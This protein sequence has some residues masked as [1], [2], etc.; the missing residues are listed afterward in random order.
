MFNASATALPHMCKHTMH[1]PHVA[2]SHGGDI[3]VRGLVRTVIAHLRLLL[4][5]YWC[6]SDSRWLKLAASAAGIQA[7]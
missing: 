6:F 2:Y 7:R 4:L 1:V 5:D 3:V